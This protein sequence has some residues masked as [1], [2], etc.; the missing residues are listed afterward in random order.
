MR[1][2]MHFT[3]VAGGL[4]FAALLSACGGGGGSGGGLSSPPPTINN[5][6]VVTVDSGPSNNSV[7]TLF[8]SVKFCIPGSTTN[9]Q[10][11]DHIQVDTGSYGLRVLSSAMTLSLP[12]EATTGGSLVECVPFVDGYSFGPVVQ[13]DI[14]VGGE[15]A[16]NL[17]VQV[18]G[19]SRFPTVPGDCSSSTTG[20][21][22]N[23]V[24]EF[25]AN[26]IL[27]IGPFAYDCGDLCAASVQPASYYACNGA[28]CNGAP[29]PLAQQVQSA[30]MHFTTDNNGAI[31]Q[32]PTVAA[33]GAATVS[34]SLIFGIDT[35]SN[36]ASGTETV[37]TVDDMAYLTVN[38]NGQSLPDSFLDSGTN[39]T[40]FNDSSLTNCTQSGI[41]DFYCPASTQNLS[42]TL[43]GAN[44]IS[45]TAD[46]SVGNAQ[47]QLSANPT[48]AAFPELAGAYPGTTST[49][50]FGLPFFYG[51]RVAVAL[52]GAMTTAGTGPYFA[53]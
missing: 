1:C 20:T 21:A 38:F 10:T 3:R 34:G 33:T 14:Y 37:L 25:G 16:T 48:F 45:T 12:L 42:A 30:I 8:V 18:I 9:C 6:A 50:D 11:V 49:F 27:G 5:V 51:K 17:P 26:G 7:N 35:E 15:I 4:W 41:T 43:T 24:A 28:A 52:D 40:Y 32:L 2:S 31:I 47:T 22:E 53:F 29:A 13:A 23:T 46:F 44:G 19:D 39:G 36:N